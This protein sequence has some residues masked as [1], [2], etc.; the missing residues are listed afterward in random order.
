MSDLLKDTAARAA[1]YVAEI[2]DR[3]VAPAP[4]DLARLKEFAGPLNDQPQDPA[5]V[6]ALLDQIGSPATVASTGGR[7]FGS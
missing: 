4:E 7:Y 2:A 6:I 3:R 1:R 5:A